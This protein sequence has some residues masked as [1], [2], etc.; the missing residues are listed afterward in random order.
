MRIAVKND[1]VFGPV[2]LLGEGGAELDT[3]RHSAVALPPLN[4]AL[5]RYLVIQ[6]LAEGKLRDTNLQQPLDRHALSLLLTQVNQIIIDHPE[7][8]ELDINPVLASGPEL[9]VVDISVRLGDPTAA[10]WPSGHT[11]KSWKKWPGYP[12]GASF[13]SVPYALRTRRLTRSLTA[14]SPQAIATTVTLP[15]C[16][17]SVTNNWPAR[18]KLTTT[19]KWPLL[20]VPGARTAALKPWGWSGF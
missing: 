19:G 6:A 10:G 9:T 2:I 3:E 14:D 15:S 4:M 7:I 13:C 5:S 18:H 17:V 12:P 16:Q 8:H 20:P 11:P 1:P